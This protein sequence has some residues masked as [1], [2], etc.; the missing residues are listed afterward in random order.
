M[1]NI[2][3]YIVVGGGSGGCAVAGRLTEDPDL[4]VTVLEA[5]GGGDSLVVNTPAGVVA[6]LPG[7]LNNWAF[8]TVPQPGLNG[9]RGYQPRGK[10]LGGSSGLNAMIY[11][12]GHRQDYD[13]WAALG[14]TGWSYD[15][16]LPYFKRSE[17]NETHHDDYHGNAGPL[18][19][20]ELRTDNPYQ[21]LLIEAG[22][23]AGFRINTDFNGAEQ[24][25]I[26]LYQLTQHNG[27]RWSASRAYLRPHMGKRPNL[28]VETG[29]YV[30]RILFE[31]KRAVGVE[32]LQNGQKK[33]CMHGMKYY[34]Q[35]VLCRPR[36]C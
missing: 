29:C 25:G 7:K 16:V 12:R 18:H 19:V 21:Q 15:E 9:R 22:K 2:S 23:Q 11:V 8:E 1:N 27:E 10:M 14:N 32:M 33:P 30:T 13:H 35:A 4:S 34:W 6:M 31:G 17:N 5:G 28:R 26:G 36:N 3:D 24:E 20:S